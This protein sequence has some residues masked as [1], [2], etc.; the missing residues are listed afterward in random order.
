MSTVKTTGH[1]INTSSSHGSFEVEMNSAK[2]IYSSR[3]S[4]EDAESAVRVLLGY[5]GEDISREGLRDTPER[6]IKSY[7]ELYSGYKADISDILDK[8][9]HDISSYKDIV[10]LKNIE[11]HSICEHHMLPFHG[12]VDMA[13][14]PN[15][16]V[17]GVSKIARLVDAC[18][19]KLQIQ[20]KMT[21]EIA[22]N[23]QLYL[24]PKGVAVRVRASH[25]CMVARG[26]RKINSVLDTVKYTG[27]FD[28]DSIQRQE[29]W[30][31][32]D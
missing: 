29:F 12:S 30:S 22:D 25:S 31:M 9:F 21:A 5:I 26:A 8:R 15:D 16:Y 11:F 10:L 24:N 6:V 2:N 18:A 23:F 19:K 7:D 28:Q 27:V 13:Y 3:P 20:E 1:A 17:V 32:L 4:A 14:I